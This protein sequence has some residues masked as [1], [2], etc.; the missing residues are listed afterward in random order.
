M[1][2][3]EAARRSGVTAKMIRHYEGIGLLPAAGRSEAGYRHYGE[4]DLGRLQFIHSARR[5]GFSLEDIRGLLSLWQDKQRASRE[6]KALAT[7]HIATLEDKVAELQR[8]IGA[9]RNLAACC[10]GD[11]RP[12]CPILDGLSGEAPPPGRRDAA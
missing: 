12:D 2:I 5:L 8:M 11:E 3:G 1:N 6:V 4:T 9:L 10:H 7:A